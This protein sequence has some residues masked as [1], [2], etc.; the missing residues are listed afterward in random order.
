MQNIKIRKF[1]FGEE[2]LELRSLIHL[3]WIVEII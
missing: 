1:L 3:I 2:I